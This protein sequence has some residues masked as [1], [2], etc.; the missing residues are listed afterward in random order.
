MIAEYFSNSLFIQYS[1]GFTRQYVL[2]F[3]TRLGVDF[4]KLLEITK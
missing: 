2:Y 3:K 4:K 1:E